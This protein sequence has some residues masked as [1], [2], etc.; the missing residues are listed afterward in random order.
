M[1]KQLLIQGALYTIIG[2]LAPV[3]A[4]LSSDRALDRRQIITLFLAGIVSGAT[5]LKAFL[6]TTF[7]QTRESELP[8]PPLA[9]RRE[10]LERKEKR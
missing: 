9:Y 7:S 1:S 4:L 5:A 6:S 10:T 3:I 2:A 8:N